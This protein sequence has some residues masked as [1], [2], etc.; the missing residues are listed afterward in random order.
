[1]SQWF[2][3]YD[4][5]SKDVNGSGF[6]ADPGSFDAG[7]GNTLGS[8]QDGNPPE[9]LTSIVDDAIVYNYTYNTTSNLVEAKA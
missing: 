7:T 5:T 3:T 9:D 1:M 6:L 8:G 4:D 2:P